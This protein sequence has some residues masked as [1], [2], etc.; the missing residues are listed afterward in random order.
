MN[1]RNKTNK[2]D[3][4]NSNL[5]KEKETKIELELEKGGRIFDESREPIVSLFENVFARESIHQIKLKDFLFTDKFKKQVECYRNITDERLKMKIKQ[6][7]PCITPSGAFNLRQIWNASS[8]TELMCIDIDC[9]HN[10]GV[11]LTKVKYKIGEHFPSLYYAGLSL[12]GKG[13]FLIFR[14]F[15]HIIHRLHFNALA[16]DLNNVFGINVDNAIKSPNSLR[17]ISYDP[18]PYFNPT[19]TVYHAVK[20]MPTERDKL[21]KVLRNRR[22]NIE[23]IERAIS[24]IKIKQIDITKGYNNWFKIGSALAYEFGEDGR[25]W[26]HMISYYHEKYCYH[27]FENQYDKCMKYKGDGKVKIGTFFFYC[28]EYNIKYKENIST[29]GFSL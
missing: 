13:I 9:K 26:F 1:I 14:I 21:P 25:F 17:I 23:H 19:P 7:L 22:E 10:E 2:I 16:F 4:P 12:G 8:Y 5:E 6:S 3:I 24:C 11:D 28:K 18:K 29:H 20:G 27:D 15:S